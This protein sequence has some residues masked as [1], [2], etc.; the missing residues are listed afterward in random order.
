MLKLDTPVHYGTAAAGLWKPTF[1]QI[2]GG[3]RL[4]K[5][6]S[7]NRYNSAVDSS[8]SLKFGTWPHHVTADTLLKFKIMNKMIKHI[9]AL[10]SPAAS[11]SLGQEQHSAE[12]TSQLLEQQFWTIF[13]PICDSTRSHCCYLDKNWNSIC[14]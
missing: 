8:I 9:F 11:L 13:R 14:L 3:G 12:G 1:G 7:L 6:Q 2:Q 4:P 5:F 10:L